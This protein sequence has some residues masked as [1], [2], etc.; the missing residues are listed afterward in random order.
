MNNS[1]SGASAIYA[2]DGNI[3]GTDDTTPLALTGTLSSTV[4]RNDAF[5]VQARVPASMP[6]LPLALS[7]QT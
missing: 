7:G 5:T 4:G 1:Q 6:D 3:Y 2:Y